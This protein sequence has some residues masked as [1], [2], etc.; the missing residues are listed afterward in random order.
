MAEVPRGG[1]ILWVLAVYFALT[2][3]KLR[4]IDFPI[5]KLRIT[6]VQD[7]FGSLMG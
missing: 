5:L 1:R 2:V 7:Y 3:L 4:I 6:Y